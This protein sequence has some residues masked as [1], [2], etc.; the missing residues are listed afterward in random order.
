MCKDRVCV[1]CN[2]ECRGHEGLL[3]KSTY[4]L[5]SAKNG[6]LLILEITY[7]F[8]WGMVKRTHQTVMMEFNKAE[9]QLGGGDYLLTESPQ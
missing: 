8:I 2:A 3:F 7:V 6:K 4:F 9:T 5:F 1:P